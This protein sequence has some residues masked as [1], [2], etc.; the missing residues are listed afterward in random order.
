M[1]YARRALGLIDLVAGR[2]AEAVRQFEAVGDWDTDLPADL[3]MGIV[4]DL[5][6][7]L[8]RAGEHDRAAEATD[9]YARWTPRTPAPDI[10]ALTARCRALTDPGDG[11]YAESLRLHADSDAP[12]ERARTELLFGEHLRRDPRGSPP[13]PRLRDP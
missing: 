12:L 11:H 3:A 1:A 13:R 10:A 5:V 7:A 6:E 9:R 4:P 8:V 2:H